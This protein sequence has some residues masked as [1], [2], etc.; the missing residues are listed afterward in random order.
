MNNKTIIL[1]VLFLSTGILYYNYTS[2]TKII[3]NTKII[4]VIDGDTLET[5]IG[6]IRLLGINTPEKNQP[7]YEEAKQFLNIYENKTILIESKEKDKYNRTLA[8]AFYGNILLNKQLLEQGLAHTYYY[9]K[10]KYYKE[11]KKAEQKA[12]K[13]QIGIWKQS[14]NSNCIQLLE[15]KYKE[16]KRCTN[17]EQLKLL[18]NCNEL[19]ITIKDQA[20]HTY[21][22]TIPKGVFTKNFSCIWNNDGDTLFIYDN[23]GMILYYEY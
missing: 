11:L 15:L 23:S 14:I 21:K 7:Y 2:P 22:E 13:N 9:E 5:E 6:K 10:D 1:I 18:N 20:T 3:T 4:R 17:Q 12:Q 19:N 16:T 8:Y